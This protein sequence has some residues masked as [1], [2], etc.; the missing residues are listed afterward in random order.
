MRQLL[1]FAVLLSLAA[2][3]VEV[4]LATARPVSFF[5]PGGIAA[6]A[7]STLCVLYLFRDES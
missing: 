3:L 7:A 6:L 4:S 5:T 2:R 1:A